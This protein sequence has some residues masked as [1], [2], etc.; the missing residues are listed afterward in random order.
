MMCYKAAM[1][2]TSS[3]SRPTKSKRPTTFIFWGGRLCLDFANTVQDPVDPNGKL[4]SWSDV[5][6]FLA[7]AARAGRKVSD[8]ALLAGS[9]RVADDV[10]GSARAFGEALRL[11]A[12]IR[13]SATDLANKRPPRSAAVGTINDFLRENEGWPA[14]VG[15][16]KDGWR[17]VHQSRRDS[18]LRQLTSIACSAAQVIADTS[19][20]DRVR[21][22]ANPACPILFYDNSRTKGRRWC[23]MAVCGN[24][25]KVSAHHHRQSAADR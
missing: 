13:V 6:D 11:R 9:A 1:T 20:P 19:A 15:N 22:C 16:T 25:A 14:L 10:E 2:K 5:T 4:R 23:S 21:K 12:A 7:A 18:A 24:R 8:G 3:D 17:L